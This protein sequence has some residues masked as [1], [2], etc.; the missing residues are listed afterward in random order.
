MT[1]STDVRKLTLGEEIDELWEK[2][3]EIRALED[4]AARKQK[5]YNIAE[6]HLRERMLK[7]NL[8][9]AAGRKGIVTVTTSVVP[10]VKDWDVFY[11]FIHRHRYYHLLERRPSVS[12]CR[13]L[14]ESKGLVPGVEPFVKEKLRLV[15]GDDQ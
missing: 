2:R 13:E 9:K 10:T 12:G 1:E 7:E 6:A 5:A 3:E 8:P 4:E 15:T 11:E 14:F